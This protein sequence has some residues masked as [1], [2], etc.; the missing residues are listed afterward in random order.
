MS[1]P[2]QQQRIDQIVEH[3]VALENLIQQLDPSIDQL[4]VTMK[5][6]PAIYVPGVK[7]KTKRIYISRPSRAVS[8]ETKI[9]KSLSI[10]A[11]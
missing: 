5:V 2:T 10:D 1:T 9:N 8:I 3:A 11:P 7:E 6:Q 4:C